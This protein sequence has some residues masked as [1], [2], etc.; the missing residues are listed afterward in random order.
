MQYFTAGQ[1]ARMR[2]TIAS[3]ALLHNVAEVYSAV[4]I[5]DRTYPSEIEN[6]FGIRTFNIKGN[7]I[8]FTNTIVNSIATLNVT[9]IDEI[10]FK[11][12]FVAQ[13]GSNVDLKIEPNGSSSTTASAPLLKSIQSDVTES[14]TQEQLQFATARLDQNVPNPFANETVIGYFVPEAASTANIRIY[15]V[16][17]RILSDIPLRKDENKI[18]IQ[19]TNYKNGMY[20]YSLFIDGRLIDTKKMV[21][22]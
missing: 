9:A 21:V 2:T 4:Y 18:Y 5:G 16:A 8:E 11:P 14:E 13:I 20:F 19:N 22:K 12:D 7:Y 6:L 17:G 15:D 10:V 3:S 1:A